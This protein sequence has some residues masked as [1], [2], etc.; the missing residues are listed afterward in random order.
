[1]LH[2]TTAKRFVFG[3][4]NPNFENK[5]FSNQKQV[6][7]LLKTGCFKPQNNLF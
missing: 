2:I 5:P 7:L 1:L 4:K 3:L 6:V